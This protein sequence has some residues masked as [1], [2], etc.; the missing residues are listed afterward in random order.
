MLCGQLWS[1]LAPFQAQNQLSKLTLRRHLS[2]AGHGTLGDMADISVISAI[3]DICRAYVIYGKI[4]SLAS[5]M[6]KAEMTWT[7][8]FLQEGPAGKRDLI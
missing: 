5:E 8:C 4:S 1:S 6:G 3:S 2:W 7:Q